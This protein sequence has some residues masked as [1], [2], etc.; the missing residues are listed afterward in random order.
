MTD[1]CR[2]CGNSESDSPSG[3]DGPLAELGIPYGP[4]Q[5]DGKGALCVPCYLGGLDDAD[6]EREALRLWVPR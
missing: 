2:V 6:Y 1:R 3:D 5:R 4:M